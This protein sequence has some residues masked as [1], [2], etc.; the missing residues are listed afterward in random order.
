MLC[1]VGRDIVDW[2]I[3]IELVAAPAKANWEKLANAQSGVRRRQ[4]IP[5]G[6]NRS[7]SARQLYSRQGLVFLVLLERRL[8]DIQQEEKCP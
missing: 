8:G 7:G 5:I 4:K 6:H 1:S 3:E 2:R